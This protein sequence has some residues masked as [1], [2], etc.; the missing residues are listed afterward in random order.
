MITAH[1][2]L[3]SIRLLEG[4][5]L[6][7]QIAAEMRRAAKKKETTW[8]QRAIERSANIVASLGTSVAEMSDEELSAIPN[9]GKSSIELIRKIIADQSFKKVELD[10]RTRYSRGQVKKTVAW[11]NSFLK[12]AGVKFEIC[13]SWR[14]GKSSVKDLD[15]VVTDNSFFEGLKDNKNVQKILW[16]G[17]KKISVLVQI[18]DDP[19]IQID[20]RHAEEESFGSMMLY[21]TG[22]KDFNLGMRAYA[23]KRG[24]KLNEY[25]L[26]KDGKVIASKSEE[27]I[28]KALGL[29][30]VQPEN[31]ENFSLLKT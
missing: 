14:R 12:K 9:I 15:V 24:Y 10:A 1:H 16:S 30:F 4:S 28:F 6:N 22:S 5:E 31:R 21:F 19:S 11:I 25:G 20:F 2:I 27:D 18:A 7:Q 29:D 26:E 3:T 8:K 17:S 23:K 13:G